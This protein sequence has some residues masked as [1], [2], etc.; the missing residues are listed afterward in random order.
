MTQ[1]KENYTHALEDSIIVPMLILPKLIYKC[2][3]TQNP[4][5]LLFL[6]VDTLILVFIEKCKLFKTGK[7]LIAKNKAGGCAQ[8]GFFLLNIFY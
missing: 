4:R 3:P 1:V 8:P 2:N 6:E 5:G 7:L